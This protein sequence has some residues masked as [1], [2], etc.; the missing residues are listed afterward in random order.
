MSL[1]PE[2]EPYFITDSLEI[3]EI[4]AALMALDNNW[5]NYWASTPMHTF[6]FVF[7]EMDQKV[8]IVHVGENWIFM[9]GLIRTCTEA[10]LEALTGRFPK[11]NYDY[12]L[13]ETDCG[14]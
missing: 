5:R 3:R 12:N 10:E 6:M 13:L 1:P 11:R 4:I 7:Y 8:A 9:D 2:L 14:G